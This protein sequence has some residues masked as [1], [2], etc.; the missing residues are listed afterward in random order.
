MSKRRGRRYYSGF[1]WYD[2]PKKKPIPVGTGIRGGGK[3]GVTWWGQQWLN[4][5]NQISDANRLPR[6]RTYANNGSVRDIRIEANTVHAKVQ[7]SYLYNVEIEIPKFRKSDQKLIGELITENPDLLSRLLNRE[8]PAELDELCIRHDIRIFPQ[9]WKTFKASCSCPDWAMPCKHLAA[10]IYLVANEIDKNPFMVFSLHDFDLL[11]WME[12]AGFSSAETRSVGA[13]PLAGL[14]IS[15]EDAT[16]G[17]FQ[18]D[19]ARLDAVDFSNMPDCR[20]NLL[21][22][23]SEKPVFYPSGDFKA[24]L[25]KAL[26]SI[27]KTSRSTDSIASG[28][29]SPDETRQEAIYHQAEIVELTL[30]E[31]SAPSVLMVWDADENLLFKAE[32]FHEWEEWLAGVP[33]G[34][35]EHLPDELRGLWLAWRFA[36]ALAAKSAIIPQLLDGGEAGYLIRWL[37][38]LLNEEVAAAFRSLSTLLPPNLLHIKTGNGSLSPSE[39]DYPQAVVS[40]FLTEMVKT[41]HGVDAL[42]LQNPVNRLFFTGKSVAF[43]KFENREYPNAIAL[44]LNRFFIAEKSTVPVLE[45]SEIDGERFDI[46][47]FIEDKSEPLAPPTPLREVFSS[48]KWAGKKLD[49]LR[50]LSALADFFPALRRLLAGKGKEPLHIAARDFSDTLF[51]TL[52]VI[53]LFG[54]RV[55]LPKSLA[56]ILRPQLSLRMEGETGR[57]WS[58]SGVNLAQMLSYKW[59]VAIGDLDFSAEEFLKMLQNSKGLVK[60]RDEYVYFDEKETRA[61]AEKLSRPPTL[62]GPEL[63]QAVLSEEYEGARITLSKALRDLIKQLMSVDL[64]PIPQGLQATLRPYQHRGFSWLC[65]NA[66][67]GFGSILADDMGLGK[68][69]QVITALLHFKEKG[70]LTPDRRALAVVPTTLLTNWEREVA[71][72]APTLITFVYHGPGRSL[73]AAKQADLVLT[74]YGIARTDRTKLEK[75]KWLALV[76]DESQNIKNPAA[77]QSKSVKKIPAAIRIALS[78]TP[79][80]NRLSEYWSVFDFSNKGFLGSLS[81]FKETYAIPIEGQRDKHTLRRFHKVTQ[82]FVLRRLKTDKSIIDDL[83]DKV[84]QNQFCNLTPEQAAIYQGVVDK[85]M[86][87]IEKSEGIERRGLV[88]SL[89]MMLKQICNHP[90]Q[91]LKKGAPDPSLSGKC[92]LLLDLVEQAFDNDEKVLVFTQFREMGELLIPMFRDRFGMD[93]PFLHGGVSRKNRDVMVEDFQTKRSHRLLLLSLKAGGTGL[94]LTA[95]SQV[96]HYDLWWNPAVEAQATDR[97]FRIGQKRNVQ[98]HRFITSAT[99]EERIDAMIQS[100]KELAELTVATGET[101]IGELSDRELRMLFRLGK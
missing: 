99:F 80:E 40:V 23:L 46:S 83:P 61:L 94:N 86:E 57:V 73:A 78:G 36:R 41:G 66:R 8:L 71:R 48:K 74:S 25:K 50:D 11:N 72:F 1:S 90:A 9:S 54:I 79:V 30:D 96:V 81:R 77:E 4:A 39:A 31:W 18:F 6:G 16:D 82:P 89:I 69:L 2:K 13:A 60:I 5:F 47:L 43:D 85:T 49:L 27:S 38:A 32:S 34:R 24:T 64:L 55:L 35:L 75:Q 100:K 70:E 56:R 51:Q 7:G 21:A 33:A 67:L 58:K 91:Y 97:A 45:I 101:W 52:P 3:Y 92:P 84:E 29:A 12:Q 28:T 19:P 15:M 17:D 20:D 65:K 22:I 10:V 53:R 62:T 59:Q 44:W 88:L 63:L 95:A 87:K 26:T 68:T 37:P 93:T 42:S 98:V 14:R 76:I